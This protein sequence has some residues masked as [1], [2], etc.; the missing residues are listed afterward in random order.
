MEVNDLENALNCASFFTN[1]FAISNQQLVFLVDLTYPLSQKVEGI[2]NLISR[3]A[4]IEK[5]KIRKQML[6]FCIGGARCDTPI[7]HLLEVIEND[8]FLTEL[9][10]GMFFFQQHFFTSYRG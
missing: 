3:G 9:C 10:L 5:I 8:T 6:S 4:Q 2:V 1:A 7:I